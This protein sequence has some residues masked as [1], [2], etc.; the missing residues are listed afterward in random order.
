M[1]LKDALP[2]LRDEAN[3]ALALDPRNVEALVA[4]GNAD[5]DSGHAARAK[6]EYERALEI[7]PSSAS[8]HLNY[9]TM[10]PLKQAVAQELAA[11]MLDPDNPTAQSNLLVSYFDLGEYQLALTPDLAE[12][13]LAPH[14]A[15]S[16][17]TLAQNYALLHRDA[18]AVKAF[19]LVRPDT[20]LGKAL[21]DAGRLTYQSVLD[22]K[23]HAQALAAVDALRRRPDLDPESEGDI[24]QLLLALGQNN[25]VLAMLPQSCASSPFGCT[26]LS[27]NPLWLPLRGAPEFAELVKKYDTVSK[28]A[29]SSSTAAPAS[30]VSL[31]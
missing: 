21:V 10:L 18:D 23:L 9:G 6:S 19:D 2:G 17:L 27:I 4:L 30:S 1:P 11:V 8:A 12:V 5:L 20:G 3:H 31:Q 13:K 15:D 14:E 24:M 29:T 28:P 25:T 26:D 16:A 22:P 7:N